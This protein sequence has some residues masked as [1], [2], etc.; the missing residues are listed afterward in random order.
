M[1]PCLFLIDVTIYWLILDFD[2][3]TPLASGDII[4]LLLD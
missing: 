4:N 3:L 1:L 2:G